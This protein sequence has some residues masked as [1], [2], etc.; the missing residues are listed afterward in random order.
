MSEMFT[1]RLDLEKV[2]V[3]GMSLGGMAAGRTLWADNRFK[4]GV[5]EDGALPGTVTQNGIDQPFLYM[6]AEE[7]VRHGASPSNMNPFRNFRNDAYLLIFDGLQ[8]NSFSDG[9]AWGVR[10]PLSGTLD[11]KRVVELT[12]AYL[13]AFFDHALRGEDEPLLKGASPDYPEVNFQSNVS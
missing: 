9:P 13:V 4:A 10:F 11:G 7:S 5:S 2:G 6:A 8:H 12:N 1:N 3:F